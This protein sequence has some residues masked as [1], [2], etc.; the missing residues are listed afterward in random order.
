MNAQISNVNFY[1]PNIPLTP[2]EGPKAASISL[3][4]TANGTYDL[5]LTNDQAQGKVSMIQGLYVDNNANSDTLT[6]TVQGSNQKI[7]V[8]GN[9]QG[10]Y[11][12][13]CPNPPKFTFVSSGN[14]NGVVV[15]LLNF[16]V[17]PATW[18]TA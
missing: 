5:D 9:T 18:Q 1:T 14:V 3:D 13:L 8:K 12:V 7:I 16:P 10:Y 6:I 4:F 15:Y 2:C 17:Q 11:P